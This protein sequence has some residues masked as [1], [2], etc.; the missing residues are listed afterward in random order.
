M[1]ELLKGKGYALEISSQNEWNGERNYRLVG[2]GKE[3]KL[4]MMMTKYIYLKIVIFPF[5]L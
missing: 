3:N 2:K 4:T 5:V 1:K